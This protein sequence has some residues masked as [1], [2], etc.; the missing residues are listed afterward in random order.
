[1][2]KP[3]PAEV[4]VGVKMAVFSPIRR[5]LLSSRGPPLLPGAEKQQEAHTNPLQH[6]MEAFP[7]KSQQ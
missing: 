3:T 4:P 2:A 7:G 1:M 6:K 5:P